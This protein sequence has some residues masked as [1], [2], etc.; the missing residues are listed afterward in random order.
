VQGLQTEAQTT[1]LMNRRQSREL[2]QL[3]QPVIKPDVIAIQEA[4]QEKS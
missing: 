4:K 2:A 3:V 1:E